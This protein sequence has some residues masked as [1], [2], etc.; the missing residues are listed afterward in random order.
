M[1]ESSSIYCTLYTSYGLTFLSGAVA[2][3]AHFK[4]V[5]L[6]SF[7]EKTIAQLSVNMQNAILFHCNRNFV[8]VEI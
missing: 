4:L 7:I 8:H 5:N 6:R 3:I 2:F 1:D